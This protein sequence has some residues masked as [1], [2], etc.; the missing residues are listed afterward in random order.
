MASIGTAACLPITRCRHA[1]G[2]L[3][4]GVADEQS[5]HQLVMSALYVALLWVL[6]SGTTQTSEDRCG[7]ATW[8][9]ALS[10]CD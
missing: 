3:A 6:Q 5:K 2:C 1:L 10:A 8:R 9:R 7:W 4:Q